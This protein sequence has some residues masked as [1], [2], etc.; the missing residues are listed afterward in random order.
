MFTLT[1][2]EFGRALSNLP[3]KDLVEFR[4]YGGD[5]IQ[6]VSRH[7]IEVI[8]S[9]KTTM[10]EGMANKKGFRYIRLQRGVDRATVRRLLLRTIS[11][12]T[13]PRAEDSKTFSSS[14]MGKGVL[15]T[16]QRNDYY[17]PEVKSSDPR[18]IPAILRF[19]AYGFPP[20]RVSA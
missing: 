8:R 15:Y 13:V 4:E 10:V 14:Q 16:H 1:E 20:K 6:F 2:P 7:E 18:D 5:L 12:N 3:S 17:A 11:R 9:Q 19:L